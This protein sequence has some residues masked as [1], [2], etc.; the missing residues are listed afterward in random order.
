[1]VNSMLRLLQISM[2]FAT[3]FDTVEDAYVLIDANWKKGCPSLGNDQA[4]AR[5]MIK[6]FM[7]APIDL[8]A[9]SNFSM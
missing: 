1:M 6:K 3:I 4:A 9:K 8:S 5:L 2:K 7:P